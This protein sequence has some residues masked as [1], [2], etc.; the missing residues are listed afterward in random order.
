ME[1]HQ[2]KHQPAD[3]HR[4]AVAT[5]IVVSGPVPD[6][7]IPLVF[8]RDTIQVLGENFFVRQIEHEGLTGQELRPN[9][10]RSAD[11]RQYR[12]DVATILVPINKIA[13]FA[14]VLQQ[15]AEAV[16]KLHPDTLAPSASAPPEA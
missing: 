10:S 6:G 14:A 13:S 5:G 12:E 16:S 7:H 1:E 2:I 9:A 11:V 3:G 4:S 15:V 8:Y